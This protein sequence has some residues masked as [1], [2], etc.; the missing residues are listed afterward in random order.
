MR[1]FGWRKI[2]N[3]SS[4]SIPT[5]E[6]SSNGSLVNAP[7][8]ALPVKLL[9]NVDRTAVLGGTRRGL[10]DLQEETGFQNMKGEHL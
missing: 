2:L 9:H 8:P 4:S 7:D 6:Q 5:S 1:S 3:N 10:L